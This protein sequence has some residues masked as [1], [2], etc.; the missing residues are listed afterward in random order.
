MKKYILNTLVI[1]G[2]ITGLASCNDNSWNN[3][4]DGFEENKTIQDIQTL[5]YTL[6][7]TDYANLAA[8]STNKAIASEAGVSKELTA[9]GTQ[10]YF[11]DKITAREYVPAFLS[12]PDFAYFTLSDG[13]AIKL[14]Y[15]VATNLPDEITNIANA[16]QFEM[17]EGLYKY[18]WDSE[19][20]YV[21][22]FSPSKPAS[23][24]IPNIL[25]SEYP[26][27]VKGEYVIVNY[28]T[29]DI[30]PIFDNSSTTPDQPSFEMSSIIGSV[31]EGSIY[32]I[33]GVVTAK[34]TSGIILTDLTG[35]IF[36]YFGNSFDYSSFNIGDQVIINGE[37]GS[38]NNGLQIVGSSATYEIVGN[39]KYEYPEPII[40]DGKAL[41]E[42]LSRTKPELAIYAQI[43]A[44]VSINGNYTNF[45]VDGAETAQGSPYY[46][47]D[48]IKSQLVADQKLTITGYYISISGGRY[49]NFIITELS[50]ASSAPMKVVSIPS[51]NEN[52]IYMFDGSKWAL[53]QNTSILNPADY[54]AMGQTYGNLSGNGPAQYLPTYLK[55]KFPYAQAEDVEFVVYKYY[56]GGTTT[57]KC[58]QYVFNGSEWLL[59]NGVT[60]ETTQ[61]V[62]RNG[63]WIYDPNVTINLPIGKNIEIST[64]YYQTCVDWV[65][66]NIDKPLGSTSIKSGKYYITSYGNNEYY[67]GT[68][69]YQGNVDL[70]AAAARQQYPDAYAD[71]TDEEVVATMKSRFCNEVMPGALSILHPDAT[72]VE[73]LDVIYTINFGVYTGTTSEYTI[74]FKVVEQGK[75][76]Y[77]D[78]TWDN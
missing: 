19:E 42:Q 66:E 22:S 29:S 31:E 24:Y 27:A 2:L 72:P 50:S 14:T 57:N 75:F 47:P 70:R 12:D 44:T 77:L 35:S 40:Y 49:C 58:D 9:V 25:S 74:R 32:D 18:V 54:T 65:Y 56:G 38:Y 23:K 71:M 7:D 10:H 30:D 37:I 45:I 33:N 59:N 76:E 20:D 53:A 21:N 34:C 51:V 1:S 48:E 26:D 61:F 8:N 17:S 62:R 69:A 6:N 41:D 67:S 36:A 60:T 11:T 73:G 15:N 5:E 39:Q 43:T 3:H 16:S 64:L 28:N 52:A 55:Q 78:C 46:V 13:S 4:L 63:T 68:S